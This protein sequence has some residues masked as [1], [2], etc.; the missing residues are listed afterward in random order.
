M[1]PMPAPTVAPPK[2]FIAART[3]LADGNDSPRTNTSVQ[4]WKSR[5]AATSIQAAGARPSSSR[6]PDISGAAAAP[7]MYRTTPSSIRTKPFPPASTTPASLR[8]AISSGVRASASSPSCSNRRMNSAISPLVLA[9]GSAAAAASRATVRRVPSR[10]SSRDCHNRSAPQRIARASSGAVATPPS[11]SDSVKPRRNWASIIPEFPRAPST[12]ARASVRAVSGSGASPRARRASA[13]E[14]SVRLKLVPV[15]PSGTGN[16]LIRLISSRPAATQ[17]AAAIAARASRGP[18]TYVIPPAMRGELLG[19]DGDANL[20]MDLGMQPNGHGV[21]ARRLDRMI[22]LDLPT[23]DGVTLP[24]ECIGDVL[25]CNRSEQLALLARL[26]GEGQAYLA[27]CRGESF[28]LASFRLVSRGTHP[29]LRGYSLLVAFRRLVRE[30][31]GQEVV[32]GIAGLD[33]DHFSGTA[34]GL[35]VLSQ[36]HFSH[37]SSSGSRRGEPTPEI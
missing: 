17:L 12:A 10:G 23:V 6:S 4:Y 26:S 8:T 24:A 14:R 31:L 29:A 5:S 30:A 7:S 11:P 2:S 35:D 34:K 3:S 32:P 37:R 16:T 36:D 22:Q 13:T 33:L 20:G 25:R 27:Q 18:S 15:S 28:G 19:N 21:R 9:T 1:S